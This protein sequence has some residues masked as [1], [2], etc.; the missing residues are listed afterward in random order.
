[1]NKFAS[2]VIST[3][4]IGQAWTL[5]L[6]HIPIYV[7]AGGLAGAGP[8]RACLARCLPGRDHR[9]IG[10]GTAGMAG[11]L[12]HEPNMRGD[13][14]PPPPPPYELFEG[15]RY[16]QGQLPKR[17]QDFLDLIKNLCT[18]CPTSKKSLPLHF[19]RPL[20]DK[21]HIECTS[22]SRSKIQHTHTH[23]HIKINTLI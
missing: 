2:I 1:M 10:L 17:N 8:H 12:G 13:I 16:R 21:S 11:V 15:G 5:N 22:P 9:L 18:P 4:F 19:W 14:K 3:Y 6:S 20:I 23:T 7:A